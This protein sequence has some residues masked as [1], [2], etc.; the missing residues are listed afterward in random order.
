MKPPPWMTQILI[1]LISSLN[2]MSCLIAF[3]NSQKPRESLMI[4]K[5]FTNLSTQFFTLFHYPY[6]SLYF[7]VAFALPSIYLR[8]CSFSTF[9]STPT[10]SSTSIVVPIPARNPRLERRLFLRLSWMDWSCACLF[11]SEKALTNLELRFPST[12]VF[13]LV[14]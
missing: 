7:C 1:F 10:S 12:S 4:W 13:S 6:V 2:K 8:F 5:T 3:P 11:D 14:T 9:Y